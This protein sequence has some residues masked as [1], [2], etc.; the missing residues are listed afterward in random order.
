MDTPSFKQRNS[1]SKP[2][3]CTFPSLK[4][5]GYFFGKTGGGQQ[6]VHTAMFG[7]GHTSPKTELMISS[8]DDAFQLVLTWMQG[9][10]NKVWKTHYCPKRSP[11][12][13]EVQ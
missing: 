13:T 9:G 2:A 4:G 10:T 3:V 8:E 6:R 5:Y 7:D 12:S 11:I 1:A